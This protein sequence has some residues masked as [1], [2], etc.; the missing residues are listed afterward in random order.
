MNRCDGDNINN[1]TLTKWPDKINDAVWCTQ[2]LV[3]FLRP[4]WKNTVSNRHDITQLLSLITLSS[5]LM[6]QMGQYYISSACKQLL[7]LSKVKGNSA[8]PR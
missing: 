3:L 1:I 2:L 4:E 6:D 5:S 8:I 7:Q